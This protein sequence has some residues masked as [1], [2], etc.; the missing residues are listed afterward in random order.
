M[1]DRLLASVVDVKREERRALLWSFAYFF[2]IL[3][4][5]SVLRPLRDNAGITGGTRALPFLTTATFFVMLAAAPLYGWLVAK[6]P[7]K[8]LIPLVYHF[9][10]AN[11][12]IFWLLLTYGV[13]QQVVLQVFFVWI[14]VFAIFA[15]PVFW[16]FLADLWRS[17]QGKRLYGFIALGGSLGALAGPTATRE[18]VGLVGPIN[19][20]LLPAA[21]LEIAIFCAARLAPAAAGFNQ[22]PPSAPPIG[23]NAF[24]GFL[25]VLKSPYL[26]G[27][28][29]WVALLSLGGTMLYFSQA[30]LV[31]AATQDPAERTRIF[32]LIDQWTAGL[33]ILLQLT[34]SGRLIKYFGTGIAAAFLPVVFALGFSAMAFAPVLAVVI[35]FQVA[36]RTSNFAV[37]NL[38]R[39]ILFTVA[40]REDKYKAK[41]VIDGVLFRGADA[42]WGWVFPLLHKTLALTIPT[43]AAITVPAMLGWAGLSLFLGKQQEKRA[44]AIAQ[45]PPP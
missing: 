15:V 7:R 9:F 8:T 27:I 41:N 40:E 34:L 1:L 26:G 42:V 29:G 14:T 17:D 2:L 43:I 16:S 6:L 5:Y 44:R 45:S 22:T 31:S 3:S 25:A 39:E 10:A 36:Q 32:A 38:A 18:L 11:L 4:A 12:V 19:L 13:A 35:A 28:A 21:L 33:Q 37:S 20:L 23:G 30:E 24:E